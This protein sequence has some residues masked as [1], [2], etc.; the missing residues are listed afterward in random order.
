MSSQHLDESVIEWRILDAVLSFFGTTLP[1][2]LS[3]SRSDTAADQAANIDMYSSKEL[4]RWEIKE[5]WRNLHS[6]TDRQFSKPA[7]RKCV[8]ALSVLLQN[9]EGLILDGILE[10]GP[11][12]AKELKEHVTVSEANANRDSFSDCVLAKSTY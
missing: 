6:L 10:A 4:F 12:P 8:R 7:F 2:A 5:T 9:L 1:W 3:N 11:H